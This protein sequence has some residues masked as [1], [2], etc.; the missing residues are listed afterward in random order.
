MKVH[1]TPCH[2]A[3]HVLYEV[4]DN[5]GSTPSLFTGDTLFVAGCGRFFEGTAKQMYHALIEVVAKL[6]Q[7]TK[8]YC[9]H[10]YTQK[11]LEFAQTIEPK[12]SAIEVGDLSRIKYSENF[13]FRKSLNG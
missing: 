2:T 5:K 4:N 10:E 1:F 9:G 11:N 3:G 8:V 13:Q 6:P 12:N 7:E